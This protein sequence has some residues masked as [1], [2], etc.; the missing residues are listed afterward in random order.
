MNITINKIKGAL[1]GAII[2]ENLAKYQGNYFEHDLTEISPYLRIALSGIDT[3]INNYDI[4]Q[5][6]WLINLE[7]THPD[8]LKYKGNLSISETALAITPI[9]LYYQENPHKLAQNLEQALQLWLKSEL[10][11]NTLKLWGLI[12]SQICQNKLSINQNHDSLFKQLINKKNSDNFSELKLIE[13][14]L[15]NKLTL[16]NVSTYLLKKLESDSLAIY[17]AIYCF[18]TLPDDFYVS[19]HRSTKINNQSILTSSL[20]GFMLGLANGYYGIPFNYR[21]HLELTLSYPEI[22]QRSS[23]LVKI[24]QGEYLPN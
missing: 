6:S 17:Q 11:P 12:I 10:N 9:I 8:Y 5:K 4:D 19:S 24:W 22:A 20:T 7:N 23:N 13:K 1:S 3:I 2:G 18:Y 16:T 21:H 15:K 14:C